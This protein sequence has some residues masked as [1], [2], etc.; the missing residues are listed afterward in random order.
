MFR[1]PLFAVLAL[2]AV[3]SAGPA[4]L[5]AAD[6]APAAKD[7]TFEGNAGL[8]QSYARANCAV[9][10]GIE[11]TAQSSPNIK[12]P[13]FAKLAKSAKLT[14]TELEGWLL[15]SHPN[16]PA[17]N[18]PAERRADLIAYIKDLALKP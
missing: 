16:M 10:H 11:A 13:P 4:T 14:A 2:A 8:G 6:A 1:S 12:A 17:V 7:T 9:C 3:T 18:V 15:S 5:P